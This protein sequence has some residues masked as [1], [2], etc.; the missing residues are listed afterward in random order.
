MAGFSTETVEARR[1][2]NIFKLLRE[3][4]WR[5]RIL[6]LV[7]VSYKNKDEIQIF[8]TWQ[9][10]I[11]TSH[12]LKCLKDTCDSG[13]HIGQHRYW[14]FL[15]L[16]KGQHCSRYCIKKIMRIFWTTVCPPKRGNFRWNQQISRKMQINRID[17]IRNLKLQT[18]FYVKFFFFS[19]CLCLP[20]YHEEYRPHRTSWR[21]FPLFSG[22]VCKGLILFFSLN[23]W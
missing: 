20:L 2:W 13:Y 16:Q 11:C 15:S 5:S 6:K 19:W 1:Q 7:E 17:L 10:F 4:N 8:Q 14:Q 22:I 9:F 3:N 18:I 12:S 23:V 21:I